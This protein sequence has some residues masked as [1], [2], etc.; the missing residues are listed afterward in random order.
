M[1]PGVDSAIMKRAATQ[2]ERAKLTQHY[3]TANSPPRVH[4]DLAAH[5]FA[6]YK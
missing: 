1:T 4:G 6:A 2:R 5:S 3:A